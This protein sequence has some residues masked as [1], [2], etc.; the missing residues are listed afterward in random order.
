MFTKDRAFLFSNIAAFLNYG[1]TFT[2]GY[3]LSIYLQVVMGFPS[4]IAGLILIVQ[5]AMQA[6]F[7]PSMGKLSDRVAPYKLASIGM[8]LCVAGLMLLSLLKLD[9]H[10]AFVIVILVL[11]G[12]GFAVFSSPNVNAIMSRVEPKDFAVANSIVATMRTL[13]Q[14]SSM[15]VV[16]I[17]T[18]VMVGNTALAEV[19]KED[20]MRT[21]HVI[22]VIFIF[23]CIAGVFFSVSR[24][25]GAAAKDKQE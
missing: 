15:A 5:P 9:T 10:L 17:V 25:K 3:L 2:V 19:P 22:F 18:G 20:L 7:S 14:T 6:L 8:S 16:T 24:G 23:I 13:G 21:I 11:M 12:L 1:A 4:Q